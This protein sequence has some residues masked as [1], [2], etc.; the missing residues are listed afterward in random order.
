MKYIKNILQLINHH[1]FIIDDKR[2][3]KEIKKRADAIMQQVP[4]PL[5]DGKVLEEPN[6]PKQVTMT[7]EQLELMIQER[8]AAELAKKLQSGKQIINEDQAPEPEDNVEN[9]ESDDV[10]STIAG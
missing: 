2:L 3:D 5:Q 6:Q 9:V 8:T 10:K 1:I 7:E 4:D